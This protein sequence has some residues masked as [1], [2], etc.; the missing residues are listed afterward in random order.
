MTS[1]RRLLKLTGLFPMMR[2]RLKDPVIAYETWGQQSRDRDNAVLI[3]TGLSPSAHVASSPE[4]P[5]AGWWEDMVG[6]DKP[7]DTNRYFVICVNSLGSCFGSTGPASMNPET[8]KPYRLTFPVL[9][10]EDIAR[11]GAEV[12]RSLG[13]ESLFA[14]VGA[15]MGGMTALAF[16][17]LHPNLSRG[18]LF[19][20]LHFPDQTP[21]NQLTIEATDPI[22]GTAEF[23]ASAVSIEPVRSADREAE[24]K[25]LA[26]SV[27]D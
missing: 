1:A 27:G 23:K 21:T 10:V 2:G 25:R 26:V 3:F 15:S 7:I 5:T 22:A 13:I 20:S 4:D 19:M 12:V 14:T 24:G 9:C 6:P 18:L 16:C 8:G 11:A 17:M